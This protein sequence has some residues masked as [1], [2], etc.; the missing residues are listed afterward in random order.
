MTASLEDVYSL[1]TEQSHLQK[2]TLLPSLFLKRIQKV[3]E[4]FL[5]MP[6]LLLLGL[7]FLAGPFLL[8]LLLPVWSSFNHHRLET[9]SRSFNDYCFLTASSRWASPSS[10]GLCVWIKQT[11]FR[12]AD[13]ALQ[14]IVDFL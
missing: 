2:N 8:Q 14:L 7:F 6:G 3:T 5:K 13:T 1:S 4:L 12:L 11:L 9:L 10:S